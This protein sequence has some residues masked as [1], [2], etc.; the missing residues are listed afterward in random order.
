MIVKHAYFYFFFILFGCSAQPQLSTLNGQCK[1]ITD[2]FY[3]WESYN[4]IYVGKFLFANEVPPQLTD[5]KQS[6]GVIL[7]GTL[8]KVVQV[9]KGSNGSY[10]DFFRVVVE[11]QNGPFA[12]LQADVPACAPYYPRPQWVQGC[13]PDPNSLYFNE[14]LFDDCY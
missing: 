4:N 3:L 8:V 7:P 1:R 5:H 12:G 11:V 10:G 6:Y 9:L 13:G 14:S 2:T